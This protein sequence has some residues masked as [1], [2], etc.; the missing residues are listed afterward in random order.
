MVPRAGSSVLLEGDVGRL[1]LSP[2]ASYSAQGEVCG[3]AGGIDSLL[4]VLQGESKGPL[5]VWNGESKG[6]R[7]VLKGE[8]KGGKRGR[9]R[10][11]EGGR[12]GA[13]TKSTRKT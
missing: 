3:Y 7:N 2:G 12:E 8:S 13:D 5:N 6:A 9:E 10:E 11:E 1:P 4:K